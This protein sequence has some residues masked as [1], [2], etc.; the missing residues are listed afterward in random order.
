MTI[1]L[2]REEAALFVWSGPYFLTMLACDVTTALSGALLSTSPV[3][4]LF[5][6]GLVS[7]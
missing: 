1:S 4:Y 2:A 3:L 7:K 5:D 6:V